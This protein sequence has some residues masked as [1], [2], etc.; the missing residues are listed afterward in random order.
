MIIFAAVG[1]GPKIA[2]RNLTV[3]HLSREDEQFAIAL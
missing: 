3:K 2:L 1:Y